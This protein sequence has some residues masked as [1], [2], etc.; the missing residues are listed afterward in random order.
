[1]VMSRGFGIFAQNVYNEGHEC[2]YLTQ[3]YALALSIKIHCG[4]QWPVFVMTNDEVPQQY[5][6][7]FDEIVPIPWGDMAENSLWKIENR[8]KMY[9]KTP[10][11]E[12]IVLDSDCLV[13]RDISH[14]W[15]L[16]E[17]RTVSYGNN[18]ITYTGQP[19]QDTYRKTFIA[20]DLPDVYNTIF[21][22]KKSPEAK[23]F[24]TMVEIIVNNWKEFYL[25]YAP[26]EFQKFPS[27]DL[28]CAIAA[29]LTG[30][31]DQIT[32]KN[33]IPFIHMKPKCQGWENAPLDWT[34]VIGSYINNQ[35]EL[36]LGNHRITDVLHYVESEFLT[37][38][39]INTLENMYHV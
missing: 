29:K 34:N 21:Y 38:K 1:M 31:S 19:I 14:W 37:P 23:A 13:M 33:F 18:P 6:E 5:K 27:M 20:N 11:R 3:A 16:L 35:G 28:T 32:D 24:F 8:W 4:K 15:D 17:G 22:F 30:M 2:D 26:K 10:Y 7:V 36:K 9:H 39:I 12:T 25:R